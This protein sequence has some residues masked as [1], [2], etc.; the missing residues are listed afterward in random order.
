MKKIAIIFI[1]GFV[2]F[3]GIFFTSAYGDGLASE[4]LPPAMIGNKNVTLSINSS[5]F[6]IDNNHVGTQINFI[7]Q[8]ASNQ[9]PFQQVTLSV[10][11][12][13]DNNAL[14]GHIFMSD[15]G[16]FLF[17]VIPDNSS[18]NITITEKGGI[19]PGLLGHSGTYD[20]KGPVFVSGGLYKFKINV[21]T[22]G[23]YDNQ[24]SKSYDAAISIPQTNQYTIYDNEDGKQTVSIIAY[25]DTLGNFQYDKDNKKMSFT[26]PFNWGPDNL[27]QVTVVHQELKI[28]RSF[29]TFVVTKY[30]AS[31]NGIQL[32]DKAISI[33]DYSSDEYR[34][35][36]LILYKQEIATISQQQNTK[37]EM[38]FTLSPSNQTAF[39]VIQ[40]TRNAQYKVSLS[41]DPPKIM[42]GQTTKLS[43]QVLDPYIVNKTVGSIS[44]DFSAIEGK[45]GLAYHKS[46]TTNSDGTPNII[47]MNLP[48][49]YTG[50][51][52]MG[53][54]NLNGNSFADA[55]FTAIV[56]R[57]VIVPEFPSGAIMISSIA[58][59]ATA[60]ILPRF[61]K[62]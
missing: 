54:E 33:D 30:D 56:S 58:V 32:P 42:A 62:T 49:N 7:V 41:W 39:P 10:A 36:H 28:P 11:A 47:D 46:G 22:L 6:L 34:I 9:V 57:P 27:K 60:L 4:I 13:K 61:L 53:F 3:S 35:I 26:M 31:V 44:Y 24:I 8:D 25:Y 38:D 52:T 16:N 21:L 2:L 19:L 50:P 43:F 37:Q 15:S 29:A 17:N 51:M 23:S 55:E 5:P 45:N 48:D 20:I 1:S 12:F 59:F 18:N 14:F 40:Y